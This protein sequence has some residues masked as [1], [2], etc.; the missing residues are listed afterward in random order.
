MSSS[1]CNGSIGLPSFLTIRH[2]LS[3][4]QLLVK[5][6]PRLAPFAA[7]LQGLL[8]HGDRFRDQHLPQLWVAQFDRQVSF[9]RQFDVVGAVRKILPAALDVR[10]VDDDE[11]QGFVF[12]RAPLSPDRGL[13]DVVVGG[14]RADPRL[15]FERDV[16]VLDLAGRVRDATGQGGEGDRAKES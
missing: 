16:L 5:K 9:E 1:A 12:R 8:D 11:A 13:A 3:A 6:I 10:P 4:I 14:K 7:Q 2:P 15:Q